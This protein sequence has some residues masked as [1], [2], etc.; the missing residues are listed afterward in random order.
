MGHP[1]QPMAAAKLEMRVRGVAGQGHG[2][3][4]SAAID[5]PPRKGP[6]PASTQRPPA[7][8]PGVLAPSSA[9]STV[10]VSVNLQ[11]LVANGN[12][13]SDSTGAIGPMHYIEIV[14]TEVG[15]YDRS[16]ANISSVNLAT[17]I[18]ATTGARVGDPQVEWDPQGGRWLYA[19]LEVYSG[20]DKLAFGWSKGGDAPGL[21]LAN[22]D[23]CNFHIDTTTN[24]HD[25]PKLGHDANFILIGA[26]IAAG[27]TTFTSASISAIPQPAAGDTSCTAPMASEFGS[28]ASPLEHLPPDGPNFVQTPVPGNTADNATTGYIAS[29]DLG[30]IGVWHV[31]PT[32]VGGCGA[33]PGR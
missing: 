25:Y 18:G 10:A 8:V 27:G 7:L 6:P 30:Y 2:V 1:P 11:G 17:F 24:L 3:P 23:W 4:T 21:T 14:N 32:R 20:D 22:T 13:P 5:T 31:T 33:A 19:S 16:L 28:Q 29:I 15:L 26:N 12:A 9:A